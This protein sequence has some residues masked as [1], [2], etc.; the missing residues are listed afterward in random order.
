L[1]CAFLLLDLFA[2][3]ASSADAERGGEGRPAWA[4][5]SSSSKAPKLSSL[6]KSSSSPEYDDNLCLLSPLYT[7]S[8]SVKLTKLKSSSES[9]SEQNDDSN[10]G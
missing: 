8:E 5:Q 3:L 7:T 2:E 10:E 4:Q 6:K 9:K 1:R